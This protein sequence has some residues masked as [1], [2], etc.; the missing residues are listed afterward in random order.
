MESVDGMKCN[1]MIFGYL[2][3]LALS[4]ALFVLKGRMLRSY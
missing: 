2:S 4:F 1:S 3:N